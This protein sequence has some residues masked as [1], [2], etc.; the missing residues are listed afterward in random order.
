MPSMRRALFLLALAVAVATASPA[1]AYVPERTPHRDAVATAHQVLQTREARTATP[2]LIIMR[3]GKTLFSLGADRPVRPASLMKLLTTTAAIVKYGPGY[4]FKTQARMLGSTLYLVGGGDPT[5]ATSGYQRERFFPKP[6]D[7][8]QIPSFPS[9]SP[10]IEQ[11]AAR[12]AGAGARTITAIVT[13]SY[14]FDGGRTP[15]GWPARFL[16]SPSPESGLLDALSLNEGFANVKQTAILPRPSRSAADA[17]KAALSRYGIARSARIVAGRA[18]AGAR[19]VAQVSSPPL[20]EIV[21]F[22]N[23]YSINF[24]AEILLKDLGADFG[25]GGSTAN[26]ARVVRDVMTFLKVPTGGLR[27]DDGSGL[28]ELDRVTPHTLATL[29]NLILTGTGTQWE[30]LRASLPVAG[31]PGTLI[32][33]LTR[34]A[35]AGNLRAK[36]GSVRSVRGMAGWVTATNG[37]PLVF[38][39]VF[40]DAPFI[41]PLARP[42]DL[43]GALLAVYPRF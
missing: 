37:I 3:G 42:L 36:T 1:Y 18:P 11:L 32:N 14:R 28:S 26:G 21:E 41:L 40:N 12:I 24:D 33:R 10:T 4:R 9:G 17:L 2:A 34:G 15:K 13:D 39:A 22:T 19:L 29:L 43:L 6:A 35:A 7:R 23:R 8:Y 25:G 5:L 30:A 31:G 38:V 16:R 27:M 20:R